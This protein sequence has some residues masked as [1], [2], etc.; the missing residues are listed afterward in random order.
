MEGMAPGSGDG[1]RG[2]PALAALVGL[3]F[4]GFDT[5]QARMRGWSLRAEASAPP[6]NGLVKL[7][8]LRARGLF[9]GLAVT[10]PLHTASI[11]SR[12]RAAVAPPVHAALRL[13]RPA[14]RLPGVREALRAG[15]VLRAR[16]AAAIVAVATTGE[17]EAARCQRIAELGS[18]EVADQT[19]GA[20]ARASQVREVV[21]EQ[22][23]GL[24][25]EALE[26]VRQRVERADDLIDAAARSVLP[27]RWRDRLLRSRSDEAA[28]EPPASG[29][30]ADRG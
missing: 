20:I 7:D 23:A 3:A 28:R 27:R 5:L 16:A 30:A 8:R 1:S 25:S 2:H 22:S 26:G 19:F 29:S 9:V 17:R 11:L 24:A 13:A 10:I 21:V 14:T 15:E 4:W 6:A 12:L 18:K